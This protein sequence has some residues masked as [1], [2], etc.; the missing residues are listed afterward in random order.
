MSKHL[1]S[2]LV[3]ALCAGTF[4][5]C[6]GGKKVIYTPANLKSAV[7]GRIANTRY[8]IESPNVI[9]AYGR[10]AV[11]REGQTMVFF[12]GD[13]LEQRLDAIK[14]KIKV[15]A[16]VQRV[17]TP[18]VHFQV[19][20]FIADAESLKVGE[21][22]ANLPA[23]RDAGEFTTPEDYIMVAIDQL[24]S[25]RRTLKYIQNKNF[26][27]IGAKVGQADTT[28]AKGA[29]VEN[30][31]INL[32][33]VKFVVDDTNE[34]VRAMLRSIMKEDS[35]FEG[36]LQYGAIPTSREE[37]E[38]HGIGGNVR[39]GFFKYMNMMVVLKFT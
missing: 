25:N 17:T 23:L 10:V 21:A 18:Y 4:A 14:N 1:K 24:T 19:D 15:G 6:Q 20:F 11:V 37:R 28:D 31:T 27:V 35:N 30:L 36:G 29:K 2:L 16:F 33:N 5:S 12:V 26:L 39:I 3:V 8:L 13:S 22:A 38:K 7:E 34:G 9:G 32:K